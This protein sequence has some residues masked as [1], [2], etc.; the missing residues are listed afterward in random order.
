MALILLGGIA[1]QIAAVSAPPRQS[2]DLYRYVWDGR[3]QAAGIDPY[4]Y[5]P[6]AQ[7]LAGLRDEFL[8]HRGADHCLSPL[9]GRARLADL[10]AGCTLINRPSVP[11]IYPPVAE[12]YFLAVH[13]LPSGNDSTTPI[14]AAYSVGRGADH[15]AAAVRP[16][17]AGPGR[18]DGRAVGVVPDGGPGGG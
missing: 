10:A 12:A 18:A 11:T 1:I 6:A 13:Y 17:T 14:Q 4:A 7:Q 2:D 16:G 3:V 8:W 5:V 15:R 9:F